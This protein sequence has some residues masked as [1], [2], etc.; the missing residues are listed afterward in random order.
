VSG[1][2][3]RRKTKQSG[4]R[5]QSLILIIFLLVALAGVLALTFDYG[6]VILAR[7]QMQTGVNAS[8]LEGLRFGDD[9]PPL[10][11]LVAILDEPLACSD[12]DN[13]DVVLQCLRN[14]PECGCDASDAA[15]LRSYIRRKAARHLLRLSF[16]DNF[17]LPENNTTIGAGIDSSLVNRVSPMNPKFEHQT[18]LGDG[19]GAAHL[20]ADRSNYIYRPDDFQTN[21]TDE[22]HGDMVVGFYDLNQ[23]TH[24]E[25]TA[26]TLDSYERDDFV[27]NRP[28][29]LDPATDF[30][31]AF[32]IRM[33]RTHDPHRLDRVSGVSSGGGG[34]PLMMG[35]LGWMHFDQPSGSHDIRRDGAIV[36]ATAI[37]HARPAMQAGVGNASLGLLGLLNARVDGTSWKNANSAAPTQIAI[38]SDAV[39]LDSSQL[40]PTSIGEKAIQALNPSEALIASEGYLLLT[41]DLDG[42]VNPPVIIGF[43]YVTN[44]STDGN[45][46]TFT[47]EDLQPVAPEN[48]VATLR[49]APLDWADIDVSLLFEKLRDFD[50][51]NDLLLAP[52]LSRTVR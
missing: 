28:S 11:T 27:V 29:P 5:G 37:A 52:V 51:S 36:R 8:A 42:T 32:L 23:D 34:L 13:E 33:R 30:V 26:S 50:S 15:C 16:D 10:R 41:D 43:G 17:D 19:S 9:Y 1:V 44:A 3:R 6:F 45:Q 18:E 7:R 2:P 38:S 48:A 35:L 24:Q 22:P 49:R 20:L 31:E 46:L 47:R 25:S 39:I 12:L 14:E 4:R 40:R 21:L